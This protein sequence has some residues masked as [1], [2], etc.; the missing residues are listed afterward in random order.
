[1]TVDDEWSH[2]S[3]TS[4]ARNRSSGRAVIGRAVI[5]RANP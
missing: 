3:S 5:G 2:D 4:A 1:M